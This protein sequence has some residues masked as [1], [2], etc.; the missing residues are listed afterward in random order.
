METEQTAEVTET[1]DGVVKTCLN[2]P[3]DEDHHIEKEEFHPELIIKQNGMSDHSELKQ[4]TGTEIQNHDKP[5]TDDALEA[6]EIMNSE[7][8]QTVVNDTNDSNNENEDNKMK[9][10]EDFSS[11][12]KE[13][14]ELSKLESSTVNLPSLTDK[15][16]VKAD[17]VHIKVEETQNDELNKIESN[18]DTEKFKAEF[19]ADVD[20]K[21]INED[22]KIE[23]VD[24]S[25][26]LGI[27]SEDSS[28]DSTD[29]SISNISKTSSPLKKEDDDGD[30]SLDAVKDDGGSDITTVM[31]SFKEE[32]VEKEQEEADK[33][34]RG[35]SDKS[36]KMEV[37]DVKENVVSDGS[38]EK[39]KGLSSE[40]NETVNQ[41]SNLANDTDVKHPVVQ[42]PAV[43]LV[44]PMSSV[45]YGM[46]LQQVTVH[47]QQTGYLTK[48]GNQHIFV[49][50]SNAS[51]GMYP[52]VSTPNTFMTGSHA[53]GQ[54][55]LKPAGAVP[56]EKTPDLSP[57]S[58]LEMI[59][60]MKWE[61]QNRV[62]DNYNWSVAFHPK[63]DELSSVSAFLLELGH[64]VVK[65]AVYKD[66]I[67]I[68]TKKKD[69][70]KLK[71]T[72][73]ESL[74]KMKTVYENTKKK[75]EHLEMKT[76]RCHHCKYQT[77]SKVVMNHHK[78][79]PH[80]E[81]PW[82]WHNGYLC[83]AHCDFRTKQTAA[84]SFH[85]EAVH[86]AVAKMP[87]K[88]GQFPCEM[89]PLDLSTKNKLEA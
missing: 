53:K 44:V 31:D 19:S 54:P 78:D 64:D 86:K 62:P 61:M 66:I 38:N 77:E 2:M 12:E 67:L 85:M 6:N 43:P 14:L 41:S 59:E 18:E 26:Q 15:A 34:S 17:S 71:E 76:L 8:G 7:N 63:K 35:D 1:V 39:E 74:E 20:E 55:P 37:S 70:G 73:V 23:S 28:K 33:V 4:E 47:Q 83:C 60:L 40:T 5:D 52:V 58:S 68:Q 13:I 24:S 29:S 51:P 57:K 32:L 65:E 56:T 36:E 80:V 88:P 49:P 9:D 72:E 46:P 75:V 42:Q 45:P 48:V 84:F 81:P 27:D 79:H 3:N 11:S 50:M 10:S 21:S 30:S 89:C 16:E 87:D 22:K 82:D 69:Q 25:K